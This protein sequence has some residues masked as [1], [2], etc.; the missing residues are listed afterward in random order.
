MKKNYYHIIAFGMT[1]ALSLTACSDQFLQDKK[2]YEYVSVDVYND[3]EGCCGRLADAYSFVL[4][5]AT[6]DPSWRF[7]STGKSDDQSKC[8]EEYS[9]FG[10]FVNPE[11]ELKTSGDNAV[12]DY[13]Q[14][15]NQNIQETP[16]G[17]IRNINEMIA[18]FEGSTLSQEQK[19]QLIGQAL[20][21]RAWRYYNMFKWYGGLPIVKTVLNPTTDV[22]VQRSSSKETMEFILD[23]LNTSAKLLKPFTANGG[24]VKSDNWGRVTSATALALKGRLLLLWASP[25]FNRANDAKRWT[26]AYDEIQADLATI[27]ACG[28]GLYQTGSNINA[29]D[30]AKMFTE[31]K[32]P[33]AVFVSLYN[34]VQNGTDMARN[35]GWESNIRPKNTSGGGGINASA[36]MVDMFPMADGKIPASA[37]TYTLL[38]T[39]SYTE[40]TNNTHDYPFMNRDPR[41]YRT[42]AMPGFRWAYNGDPT[43]ANPDNPS[44]NAGSNYVLWN[45]VWYLDKNDQGNVESG[46][47][48]GA[49]NLLNNTK[50]IY[51]RK[52]SDDLDVNG[53]PLYA[54]WAAAANVSGF[55]NSAAPYIEIRYAEVLLNYAEAACMTGHM[56][57]AVEQLQKIRARVGYTAENNYGLQANLSNDQKACMSAILYERQI[58]LA[59]EGKRFDD[60]RRWMLFDG[61]VGVSSIAGAPSSWTLTG[62][63][64]NTCTWLGF[65]PL[66]GQRRENMLFRTADKWGVGENN[67]NGDPLV[68]GGVERPEGVDLR[69]ELAPQLTT[70]KAWYAD[71]LVRRESRGDGYDSSH[72]LEYITFLAKYYLLGLNGSAMSRNKGIYQTIGWED[73]TR[74]NANGTFDP[75]AE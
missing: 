14:N 44:Y 37:G 21:L 33:E 50:G 5:N 31:I 11:V 16:W 34:T 15:S 69:K 22:F 36:M 54:N 52:R 42:F 28:H 19:D 18:G 26:T 7:N 72:N 49:D 10:L 74:G 20:F 39:S 63:D 3:F 70:L 4:P 47:S 46:T 56:E 43:T 24:W 58:E 9:S 62:W 67:V 64:G 71:N 29:S 60:L 40:Q 53:S 61:G 6:A 66:N 65:K 73:N 75:L 2:N 38:E 13:F 12:P 48:Y 55:V 23:D 68:K 27:D 59:Y 45:Y 41:F 17:H 35:N 51:V 1:V 57:E 32:S 8:T 25:L 30:F